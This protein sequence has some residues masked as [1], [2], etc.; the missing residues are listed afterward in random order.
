MPK[1]PDTDVLQALATLEFAAEFSVNDPDAGRA[2]QQ[3]LVTFRRLA[4]E[5]GYE[6][7]TDFDGQ[8][9]LRE[10]GED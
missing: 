8:K 9:H 2:E 4:S 3:A 5:A 10:F 6:V 7:P 1:A